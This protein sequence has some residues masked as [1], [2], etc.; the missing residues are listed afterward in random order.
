MTDEDRLATQAVGVEMS[1]V[2][3]AFNEEA[4]IRPTLEEIRQLLPAAE[5]IVVDD[6]STDGTSD[7]AFSMP[8]VTVLRHPFNRGYGA[9]LKSGTSYASREY[10]AWFDADREHPV[11]ALR[12][13]LEI[14]RGRHVAA[15]IAQRTRSGPSPL[16]TVGKAVIRWVARML[17]F[18]GG[19]DIN[20]GLRIFRKDLI[21]RYLQLLPNGFSAS[22]TSTMIMLERGYPVVYHP[23]I[24]NARAGQSKVKLSDGY[25]AIMQVLRMIMLFAPMRI[26]LK[27]GVALGLIGLSYGLWSALVTGR[28]VPI[29]AVLVILTG[30]VSAFV[31]LLADQLSQMRLASYDAPI[32]EV[33][34]G[35]DLAERR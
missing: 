28:G 19:E 5:V 30:V 3:P 21:A 10:V 25:V 9:A 1:I 20:C 2:I 31:G 7:I 33:V 12:A 18:E 14:A 11:D 24:A 15:V 6:G 4:G 34:K 26:F 8:G 17:N 35:R 23:I 16:R 29:A 13:M 22:I 32:F 27:A